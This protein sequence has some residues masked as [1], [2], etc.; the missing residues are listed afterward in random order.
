[1][2][3]MPKPDYS[4]EELLSI[5]EAAF[6]PQDRWKNRDSASAQRQLGECYALLKAGCAFVVTDRVH[7]DTLRTIGV[8]ITFHGF[9]YFE[10]G[11]VETDS[12]YLPTRL[13]LAE[14]SMR[15]WY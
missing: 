6:V 4:R 2:S 12:F 1:M 5:C 15:D 3:E 14:S 7:K 11:Y 9:G 8:D 10:V 13:R